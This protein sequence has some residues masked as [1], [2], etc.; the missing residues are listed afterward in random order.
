MFEKLLGRGLL[1]RPRR[2]PDPVQR[3]AEIPQH[4]LIEIIRMQQLEECT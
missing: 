4:P 2:V 3:I 1:G